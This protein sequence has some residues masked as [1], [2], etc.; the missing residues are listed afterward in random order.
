MERTLIIGG[1][2][3]IGS[4]I[5]RQ[6]AKLNYDITIFDSLDPEIHPDGKPP[7]HFTSKIQFIKGDVCDY[8]HLQRVIKDKSIVIY[9]A[10]QGNRYRGT[11][12]RQMIHKNCS[13]IANLLDIFAYSEHC[14]SQ[15]VFGS[16]IL[17]A[18]EWNSN[19]PIIQ[20]PD[21]YL[22]YY[23]PHNAFYYSQKIKETLVMD[24]SNSFKFPVLILRYGSVFG[25]HQSL[26]DNAIGIFTSF[27]MKNQP[28]LI[29]ENDVQKRDFIFIDDAVDQTV[30]ALCAHT[31]G[32]S[33]TPILSGNCFSMRTIACKLAH[34]LG[35]DIEPYITDKLRPHDLPHI[36]W[37]KI[38]KENGIR[39]KNPARIDKYLKKYAEWA[40]SQEAHTK[41]LLAIELLT[42]RKI[43]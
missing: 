9:L 18:L 39:K 36:E 11:G 40:L 22:S 16:S 20:L 1:A 31:T 19:E 15:F 24:F 30:S 4:A 5:A 13:G 43:L 21:K 2:G 42:S 10:S 6:L 35:K 28:P 3:F 12:F 34:A 33:V 29:Y 14:C 17:C 37:N 26:A 8:N 7:T 23:A 32:L 38:Y 27:L 25:R 41:Y